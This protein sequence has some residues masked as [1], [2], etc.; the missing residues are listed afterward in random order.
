MDHG[1]G[2]A[3]LAS[4]TPMTLWFVMNSGRTRTLTASSPNYES[5]CQTA[6]SPRQF[7]RGRLPITR[8]TYPKPSKDLVKGPVAFYNEDA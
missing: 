3:G 4:M 7:H 2:L 8:T 5:N 1:S 6:S